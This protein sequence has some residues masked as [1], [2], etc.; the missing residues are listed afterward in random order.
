MGV[1]WLD[2]SLGSRLGEGRLA[3]LVFAMNIYQ[4]PLQVCVLAVTTVAIV[5]FSWHVAR[6]DVQRLRRDL[7][8]ALRIAAFFLIPASVALIVLRK[9]IV[10]VLY[11]RGL[12]DA[13]DTAMTASLLL[14]YTLGLFPQSVAIVVVRLFLARKEAHNVVLIFGI[15]TA[16]HAVLDVVL[17]GALQPNL[18]HPPNLVHSADVLHPAAGIALATS[19][20]VIC[21][22]VTSLALARRKLG[23]LGGRMILFSLARTGLAAAGMGLGLY[24]ALQFTSALPAIWVLAGCTAAGLLAYF[25][26]AYL[27]RAPELRILVASIADRTWKAG[28]SRMGDER[29][30]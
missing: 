24:A 25:G 3:S 8:L 21:M 9:P 20:G 11:E 19:A 27:T 29:Q 18:V 22:A 16:V 1:G 13:Q 26:L 12:F 14:F 6:N 23:A 5:Q 4:L 15:G 2:R 7:N 17:V 28:R 10:Q 30:E